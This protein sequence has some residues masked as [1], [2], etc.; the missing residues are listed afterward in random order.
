LMTASYG[1]RSECYSPFLS[2]VYERI[3]DSFDSLQIPDVVNPMIFRIHDAT[4]LSCSSFN[5]VMGL[6][7]L[8]GETVCSAVDF[9][10]S[11]RVR[12][13]RLQEKRVES[14]LRVWFGN[15]RPLP[16]AFDVILIVRSYELHPEGFESWS[17]YIAHFWRSL[18]V[19]IIAIWTT[20]VAFWRF[21]VPASANH[22]GK[23][24]MRWND[25]VRV[26]LAMTG[27]FA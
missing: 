12:G 24:E 22:P 8:A 11:G 23:V 18:A 2:Q 27:H 14:R 17:E 1:F 10:R 3:V 26:V 25:G 21:R 4:T 16:K 20:A 6:T 19:L 7:K 13:R 15:F 5:F 9:L